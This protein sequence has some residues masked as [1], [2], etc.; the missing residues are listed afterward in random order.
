MQL[1]GLE[2]ESTYCGLEPESSAYANSATTAYLRECLNTL[3]I[4]LYF[5]KNC[6]YFFYYFYTNFDFAVSASFAKPSTSFT[7]ISASI[8]LF[9]SIPAC[10]KPYINLL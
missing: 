9:I 2:P 8:F 10:F 7:A 3:F 4:I 5:K 6:K 1:T